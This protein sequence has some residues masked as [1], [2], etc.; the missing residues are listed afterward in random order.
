MASLH[1]RPCAL[2]YRLSIEQKQTLGNIVKTQFF[3]TPEK[4]FYKKV[5]QK[6]HGKEVKVLWYD[7]KF[8]PRIDQ[9]IQYFAEANN[10]PQ[11]TTK[12]NVPRGTSV[13]QKSSTPVF[14]SKRKRIPIAKPAYS[15]KPNRK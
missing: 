5:V 12:L 7:H 2:G 4:K 6:E 15:A 13:E 1:Q 14:T 11:K 10:I 8:T 3:A 9:I